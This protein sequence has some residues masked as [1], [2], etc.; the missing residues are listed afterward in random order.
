MCKSGKGFRVSLLGLGFVSGL[1]LVVDIHDSSILATIVTDRL[2]HLLL[3]PRK[4]TLRHWTEGATY[5]RQGGHHVGHWLT[6]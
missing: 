1:G 4:L 5:V 6:F 3:T 2:I